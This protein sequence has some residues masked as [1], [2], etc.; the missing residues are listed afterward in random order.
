M[1]NG[2]TSAADLATPL[3][4]IAGF[5]FVGTAIFMSGHWTAFLSLPAFLI[6][7]G[8]TVAMTLVSY[9]FDEVVET[10]RAVGRALGSRAVDLPDMSRRLV[11][12]AEAARKEGLRGLEKRLGPLARDPHLTRA[13]MLVVDG[14][15]PEDLERLLAAELDA[16]RG[17]WIKSAAVLR[18]AA[19]VAPAMGLIGTLVGLVQMLTNLSDP[20]TIGPA[21]AVALLT[22]FYGAVLGNM[23][24]APLAA[25]VERNAQEDG[26]RLALYAASA[27][28][29]GR[30]E[31]PRRLQMIINTMLPP[32]E[33]LQIYS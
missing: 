8:G 32:A 22:T 21:M 29:I 23:V 3:G 9:R 31:S 14:T 12:L 24:L 28:A 18:R 6:V 7:I 27:A 30:Q 25:K 1:K 26:V 13:L 15:K 33:Q 10:A 2:R 11:T 20:A 17:R 16:A 4:L 5:V 19:E